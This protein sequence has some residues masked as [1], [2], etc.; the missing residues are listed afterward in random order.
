[1]RAML[2][3]NC[4]SPTASPSFCFSRPA[5]TGANSFGYDRLLVNGI[6]ERSI[7][8]IGSDL[9][10]R[11]GFPG[12]SHIALAGLVALRAH[13]DV[14]VDRSLMRCACADLDVNG[15]FLR[16]VDQA[17]T[18]TAVRL[19]AGGVTRFEHAL[20]V[21][22]DERNLAFEYIDEFILVPMP[23]PL[24]RPGARL[25]RNQVDAELVEAHGVAEALAFAADDR[26]PERLGIHADGIERDF[27]DIDL[28]H[29][30][31]TRSMIVAVPMP[32]PMHNVTSAVDRSRRSSSSNTVP[33]I[34]APVAPSGWPMAMAP[35]L[36]L[37]LSW[38]MSSACM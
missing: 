38:S 29:C 33:R 8:G 14:G 13:V 1:M 7:F 12:L 16:T 28:R 37:I 27:G 10:R 21:V 32:T 11:I 31:R 34:M 30:R 6:L 35:P 9:P 18:D 19:P 20:A 5:I 23:M 17:M 3:P 25:Q 26:L 4:V 15:V 24:R 22:L 36:T 2:T